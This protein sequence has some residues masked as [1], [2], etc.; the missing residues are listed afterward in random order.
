MGISLVAEYGR[1]SVKV[2]VKIEWYF[3]YFF[4]CRVLV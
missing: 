2:V 3:L 1:S 4:I